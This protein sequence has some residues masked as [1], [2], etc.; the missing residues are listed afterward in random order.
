MNL[1]VHCVRLIIFY[2]DD[3]AVVH[4]TIESCFRFLERDFDVSDVTYTLAL[5]VSS[6]P[7]LFYYGYMT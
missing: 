7:S 2:Q 4:V 3:L 1:S 6:L 5:E